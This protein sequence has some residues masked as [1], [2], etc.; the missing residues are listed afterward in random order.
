MGLL[1]RDG[2][3]PPYVELLAELADAVGLLRGEVGFFPRVA[4]NVVEFG[5]GVGEVARAGGPGKCGVLT[6][7]IDH[8]ET[9]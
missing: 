2:R 5:P 3:S 1:C 8:R 6:V 9:I 7:S 4:D